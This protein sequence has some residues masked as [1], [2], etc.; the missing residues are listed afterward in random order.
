MTSFEFQ[1]TLTNEVF[2]I[3]NENQLI[4]HKYNLFQQFFVIGFDPKIM[5]NINKIDLK[6]LPNQ[7]LLP[8]IISKYPNK[9]LG[10]INIPDSVVASHCFP[11]G[12][13][14]KLIAY[15]KDLNEKIKKTEDWIF[16]LDNLTTEDKMSSLKMNK[17]YY[18]CYL[19]YENVDNYKTLANYR[20]NTTFKEQEILEEEKNERLLIP[21]VICISSFTPLYKHGR[22]LLHTIK[23][24]V[25]NF[26]FEVLFDK[27]NFYPIEKI[28]EGLIFNLPGL[29]RGNFVI[30]LSK[31]TFYNENN[32]ENDGKTY[33]SFMGDINYKNNLQKDLVFEESPAN[34]R[35]RALINYSLIMRFFRIEE[36]FEIIRSIILEEPILFFSDNIQNLTHTIE[37]ILALI[38]PL[39]YPYPVVSVLPEENYSLISAFN[40]FIFGINCQFSEELIKQKIINLDGK[41]IVVIVRIENRFNNPLNSSEK[42]KLKYPVIST[43]KANKKKPLI[44]LDQLKN[45]GVEKNQNIDKS[46]QEKRKTPKLPIHYFGKCSKRLEPL[47]SSK[48]KEA[49]SRNKNKTLSSSEKDRIFNNEMVENFIY[50]FTCILLNYQEFCYKF[51]RIKKCLIFNNSHGNN[52]SY[53]ESL[54]EEEYNYCYERKTE[55]DEKYNMNK[56]GI[57][58]IF[59]CAGFIAVTPT[60]DRPFYEKFFQT[61]IFFNFIKKKIF[62]CSIQDKLDVLYF[63]DKV[64]EKLSREKK[65]KKIETKFIEDDLRNLSGE[66]KIGS[67]RR[68][69][70][71][72]FKIYLSNKYNCQKG[73]NYFQYIIKHIDIKKENKQNIRQYENEDDIDRDSNASYNRIS[74]KSNTETQEIKDNY[75]FYYF[76]FPKLLNDGIFF[77]EKKVDETINEDWSKPKNN[78]TTYNSNCLYNQFEKEGL[79]IVNNNSMTVN[80]KNYNYSLNPFSSYK[81]QYH[82]CIYRLWLQF[83]AKTFYG[84]PFSQKMNYF[85]QIIQFLKKNYKSIDDNTLIMLFNAI[86][87]Y[88]DR[89]MNQEFFV[90]LRKK[91]Y[92]SFLFLREKTK[93]QN[94]YVDFRFG[95]EN[96]INKGLN[97]KEKL[98]HGKLSFIVNSFCTKINENSEEKK[99]NN[100]NEIKEGSNICNE[101]IIDEI[102]SLY[103]E[104]DNYIQFECNKCMKKQMVIIS[105]FYEKNNDL[106]YHINFRLVSPMA[107]LKQKWFKD[108]NQINI[109]IIRREYIGCYLSA[110]FYFHQQG[111][112]FDFLL[113]QTIKEKELFIEDISQKK[114][115]KED[116]QNDV[117]LYENVSDNENPETIII[118]NGDEIK[119]KNENEENDEIKTHQH[120]ISD[121][122][123]GGQNNGFFESIIFE[124]VEEEEE[125]K[126]KDVE[127]VEKKENDEEKVEKKEKDDENKN[128]EIKSHLHVGSTLDIGDQNLA[129]FEPIE[130]DVINKTHT[131]K[132]ISSNK[133]KELNTVTCAEFKLNL[134]E[135]K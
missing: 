119:E 51:D 22:F 15:E 105:C 21:K 112:V 17:I 88:G 63:D 127:K 38:Y 99:E 53:L 27:N 30:K 69:I 92:T 116:I 111:L 12:L 121:L 129:F 126:E 73:L 46:I 74:T 124:N 132:K 123:L 115:E 70:N 20:R 95:L 71:N 101:T 61:K 6:T 89:N 86:Y 104:Q 94:N 72:E 23:R 118:E 64:N 49:S 114:K 7:L 5:Y 107:I 96:N 45:Y 9:D 52:N 109:S 128:E 48:L 25:E 28:I 91:S 135:K 24:Y 8:K 93:M 50:F 85:D 2:Y 11:K 32:Q 18:T 67:F 108:S 58:D 33:R 55:L 83:L 77:K 41:K 131:V 47:I 60:L 56:L 19:F 42:D 78:F 16:S 134:E 54:S 44:K 87:K 10:Y 90:F 37:G 113:P 80:Y 122:D 75:K 100:N 76:V 4:A 29:P 31:E 98:N 43:L 103:N 59:N 62:A 65:M 13:L 97:Q 57:N 106:K 125:K 79:K 82:V 120:I 1:K 35:P 110:L 39:E 68:Q 84:I 34:R 130:N 81:I 14:K 40:H 36:I 117:N 133:K 66:I 102:S 3:E 26:N